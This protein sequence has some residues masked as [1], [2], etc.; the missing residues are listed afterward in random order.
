MKLVL[1]YREFISER[2]L[3]ENLLLESNVVYSPKFKNVLSKM[4]D[5]NIA[6]SLLEIEEQDLDVTANFFDVKIDN[7]NIVTFTNDRAAQAILRTDKEVVTWTGNR[8]AWLT[9]SEANQNIF[10]RLGYEAPPIGTPVYQPNRTEI[11]EVISKWLS[12]KTNKTW[13][14]VKFENGEGVYNGERLKDAH[15]E[16]KKKIFTTSRQEIRVG[17]AIRSLLN[18]KSLKF[19]DAEIEVFVNEF[20]GILSVMNDVFSRFE[21]VNGEELFFWYKRENY[22]F[23]RM[24][25]LGSSCQAVGRRDWLEIYIDNP[26]TVN[27]LILKSFD[28][29]NK[30][31]GRA[32]IW[33]LEDG[34]K[35]MDYIYVSKDSDKNV[36]KEYAKAKGFIVREESHRDTWVA[37][38]KPK[39]E[40]YESYPSIDTM[41]HWDRNSGKLSN[42]RFTD[43]EEIHW[44][45]DGDGDDDEHFEDDDY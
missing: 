45:N 42:N 22:E 44:D 28:Q 14:Y 38:L 27:L 40:G 32:L 25:N 23:A 39:P 11:G 12:A 2:I 34:K 8:G 20:R 35:L 19:T 18:A 41:R 13:C 36:F 15:E 5:N 10:K 17:R 1:E 43:S 30:I 33:N 7:D 24:G 16:L 26:D 6:K 29:P 31:I 37:Y 3:L 21:I 4:K 9:N